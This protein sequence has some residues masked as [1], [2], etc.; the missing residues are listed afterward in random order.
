MTSINWQP[1]G[2]DDWKAEVGEYMLRAEE[3]DKNKWWW[4]VYKGLDEIASAVDTPKWDKNELTAK[5]AA[6]DS[7]KRYLEEQNENDTTD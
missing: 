4:A 7:L 1:I 6:E 5:Q 3:M 2:P